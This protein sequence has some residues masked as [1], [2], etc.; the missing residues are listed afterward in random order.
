MSKDHLEHTSDTEDQINLFDIIFTLFEG[1]K[2]ISFIVLLSLV[3]LFLSNV[4]IKNEFNSRLEISETNQFERFK[5]EGMKAS[6]LR[7]VGFSADNIYNRI[8]LNLDNF[9]DFSTIY[10]DTLKKNKFNNLPENTQINS[11][12]KNNYS[13]NDRD[14]NVGKNGY[15][16]ISTN[17]SY[18]INVA[19]IQKLLT[20]SLKKTHNEIIDLLE[21]ELQKKEIEGKQIKVDH[22]LAI[23]TEMAQLIYASKLSREIN[24]NESIINLRALE[25]SHENNLRKL[26]KAYKIAEQLDIVKPLVS[27]IQQ[28]LVYNT[29]DKEKTLEISEQVDQKNDGFIDEFFPLFFYGTLILEKEKESVRE[30]FKNEKL[31]INESLKSELIRPNTATLAAIKL[32]DNK[33]LD[34]FVPKLMSIRSKQVEL[35]ILIQSLR[36]DEEIFMNEYIQYDLN[37]IQTSSGKLLSTSYQFILTILVGILI[38]SIYYTL[39]INFRKKNQH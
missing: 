1:W 18:E 15:I 31:F 11:F 27:S 21:I 5:L 37:R 29:T 14:E 38:G 6:Q 32:L 16:S 33:R 7:K 19:I 26:N 36:D 24:A 34:K 17:I 39:L 12:F 23:D 10:I 30:S 2:H 13:V 20:N 9:D 22:N 28:S 8:L 35:K 4:I 25:K 3:A